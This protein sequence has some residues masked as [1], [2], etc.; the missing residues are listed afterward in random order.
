MADDVHRARRARER[1]GEIQGDRDRAAHVDVALESLESLGLDHQV[2]RVGR[3]VAE[4]ER[5]GCVRRRRPREP[6]YGIPDRDFHRL[7]HAACRV[8]HGTLNPAC[9]TETLCQ[10]N[11]H[12]RVPHQHRHTHSDANAAPQQ[13][14]LHAILCNVRSAWRTHTYPVS[15]TRVTG[16][17]LVARGR[18]APG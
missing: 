12:I 6:R 13:Q 10:D 17:W 14:L 7:H 8:F 1:E 9:A 3:Q 11:A 4:H 5:A 15:G 2:V 18:N 16:N